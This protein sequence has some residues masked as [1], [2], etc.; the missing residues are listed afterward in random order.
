MK[1]VPALLA[2]LLGADSS[3]R[4]DLFD[5]GRVEPLRAFGPWRASTVSPAGNAFVVYLGNLIS[6]VDVARESELHSLAGH[7]AN[8]HDTGW[9]RDGRLLAS[10]SYDGTVRVWEVA[11]GRPLASIA[12]HS[13]YA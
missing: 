1:P 8:I 5:P 11:T 12:A 10:S 7:G 4:P 13:G 3:W 6:V 2:L 9:S